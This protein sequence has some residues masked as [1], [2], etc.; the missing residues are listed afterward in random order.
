MPH[1][2]DMTKE[3]IKEQLLAHGVSLPHGNAHK[4][5]YV[6][7][8]NMHVE[9]QSGS[10]SSDDEALDNL[11]S[12]KVN[13]KK[14]YPKEWEIT[15]I[16][17]LTNEEISIKLR[18]F[19]MVP[20]PIG[21]STRN[22]YLKK[23]EK[24]MSEKRKDIAHQYSDDEED[25]ENEVIVVKATLN[26]NRHTSSQPVNTRKSNINHEDIQPG[27]S[28]KTTF[29]S[30]PPNTHDAD[31]PG[32][33]LAQQPLQMKHFS[34]HSLTDHIQPNL[35]IPDQIETSFTNLTFTKSSNDCNVARVR[36][37]LSAFEQKPISTNSADMVVI[38]KPTY[39]VVNDK[40]NVLPSSHNK[41]M[42]ASTQH[43]THTPRTLLSTARI[44]RIRSSATTRRP[45]HPCGDAKKMTKPQDLVRDDKIKQE[46]HWMPVWLQVLV[47]SIIAGF[48]YLVFQTMES[49][50]APLSLPTT[51]SD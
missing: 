34:L 6:K 32:S 46:H 12:K 44:E 8:Y 20:G 19:G 27:V 3:E 31:C 43:I 13:I 29:L 37:E 47:A 15:N 33:N 7:L 38:T 18:F 50:P 4:A 24:F 14:T 23:L 26:R 5:T 40:Q 22:V 41:H 25:V 51:N 2:D 35:L 9:N 1:P 10:F 49:N 36:Q 45:L 28:E 11:Y 39:N 21:P 17:Q 48:I 42:N 16:E 30:Q